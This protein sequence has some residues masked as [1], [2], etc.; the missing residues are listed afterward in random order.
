MTYPDLELNHHTLYE[1][2][3]YLYAG[4]YFVW[5]IY[6][7]Y[8]VYYFYKMGDGLCKNTLEYCTKDLA[9]TRLISGAVALIFLL[10]SGHFFLFNGLKFIFIIEEHKPSLTYQTISEVLEMFEMV[11]PLV[12]GVFMI[13]VVYKL[14]FTAED[15]AIT[16]ELLNSQ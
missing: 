7:S 4:A 15:D 11:V 12:M 6:Y 9:L 8:L 5:F 10:G 13:K 14:G 16:S 3:F 1:M 2:T